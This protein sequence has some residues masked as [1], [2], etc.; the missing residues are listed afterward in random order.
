MKGRLYSAAQA[1]DLIVRQK[2]ARIHSVLQKPP[3]LFVK[4]SESSAPPRPRQPSR[5][6]GSCC[7]SNLPGRP[8]AAS[9]FKGRP[10]RRARRKTNIAASVLRPEKSR[11]R[12]PPIVA[13]AD[14]RQFPPRRRRASAQAPQIRISMAVSF[15]P[16]PRPKPA[17]KAHA[18]PASVKKIR[19]PLTRRPTSASALGPRA[20]QPGRDPAPT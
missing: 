1:V 11:R 9:R 20:G 16:D 8:S 12:T 15:T 2:R 3:L 4:A 19:P 13:R 10:R 18:S 14:E 17:P 5:L 6:V 7:Q